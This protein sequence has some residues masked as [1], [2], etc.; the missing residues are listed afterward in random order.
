MASVMLVFQLGQPMIWM[1]MSR[2]GLLPSAFAKVHKKHGTPGFS[3]IFTGL[4]VGIPLLFIDMDTVVDLCSIGTLFAFILVC[5]GVL[6][7]Q[8][9]QD[10]ERKFRVPYINGRWIIL[11]IFVIVMYY[12]GSMQSAW[13]YENANPIVNMNSLPM[14][15]FFVLFGIVTFITFLKKLSFIPVM[16]ILTCMYLVAQ[17]NIRNW[18]GFTIWLIVG[19]I[20]YFSFGYKNSKLNKQAGLTE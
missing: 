8:N 13:L 11:A 1:S 12:A 16:G 20:I 19:I 2:D 3:T 18:I 9:K 15:I 10:I 5:A 4:M 17:I 14:F 7:L 6:T